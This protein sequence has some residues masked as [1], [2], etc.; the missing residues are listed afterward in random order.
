MEEPIV[1]DI[2]VTLHKKAIHACAYSQDV[3]TRIP[4]N[5]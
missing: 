3:D 5:T 4:M 2:A 1:L